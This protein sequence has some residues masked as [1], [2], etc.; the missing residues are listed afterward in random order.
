MN[1]SQIY[2][3]NGPLFTL[4]FLVLSFA[5][6]GLIIY[7]YLRNHFD[8]TKNLDEFLER[9]EDELDQSKVDV[10][11][12]MCDDEAGIVSELLM[13]AFEHSNR[14]KVATRNAMISQIRQEILPSLTA[15]MAWILFIAKVA[16]M[17]GLLGTVA[18]M[19]S[20]FQ[21]IA[22]ATKVDPSA[23]AESIGMALFTTL[24]GLIIAI[25][26]L[27]FYTHLRQRVQ[28]FEIDL[29]F[30]ADRALDMLPKMRTAKAAT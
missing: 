3:A 17:V 2:T 23:L 12:Q 1:L 9:V 26:V 28:A 19:I 7:R 22:G 11:R 29:Q 27:F 5:A 25:F 14:G 16:P 24:E 15:G 18:G 8:R 6:V 13:T 4:A 20:A 30:A 10:A 21:K